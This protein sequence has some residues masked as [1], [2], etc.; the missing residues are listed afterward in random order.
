MIQ[1]RRIIAIAQTSH[2]LTAKHQRFHELLPLRSVNK[3]GR[4]RASRPLPSRG[5]R[6]GVCISAGLMKPSPAATLWEGPCDG[7]GMLPWPHQFPYVC[8]RSSSSD[9]KHWEMPDPPASEVH[10]SGWG[11]NRIAHGSSIG[12]AQRN[13]HENLCC[14]VRKGPR[15]VLKSHCGASMVATRSLR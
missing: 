10:A 15:C 7:T 6:R 13:L 4:W 5:R 2:S 14:M 3:T 8:R 1:A 9:P 11:A 12:W